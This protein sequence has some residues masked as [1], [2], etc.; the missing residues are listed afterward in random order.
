MKQA[1]LYFSDQSSKDKI[2]V[3]LVWNSKYAHEVLS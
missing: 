3:F 1:L 2:M